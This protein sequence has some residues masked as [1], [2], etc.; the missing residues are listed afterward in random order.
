M[1][2]LSSTEFAETCVGALESSHVCFINACKLDHSLNFHNKY[3]TNLPEDYRNWLMPFELQ[4]LLQSSEF[5]RF[6]FIS[7]WFAEMDKN[8]EQLNVIHIMISNWIDIIW[9][10]IKRLWLFGCFLQFSVLM[11]QMNLMCILYTSKIDT[12]SATS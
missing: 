4:G 9:D 12:F 11:H 1:F 2:Q 6:R 8:I 5:L 10:E 7:K 3:K